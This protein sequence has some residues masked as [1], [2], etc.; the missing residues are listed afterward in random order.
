MDTN[1]GGMQNFVDYFLS[2]I[3]LHMQILEEKKGIYALR[4]GHNGKWKTLLAY[5]RVLERF[6]RRAALINGARLRTGS[7]RL[8]KG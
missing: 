7:A 6:A 3:C 1:C 4:F 2:Y 8:M 5:A